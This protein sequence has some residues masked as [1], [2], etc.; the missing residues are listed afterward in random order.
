VSLLDRGRRAVSEV[1]EVAAIRPDGRWS[2]LQIALLALL[3]LFEIADVV[4]FALAIGSLGLEA[5]Q[6]PLARAVYGLVGLA[7]LAAVKG[8]AIC[9]ILAF[10]I[11]F[12]PR[13]RLSTVLLAG[14]VALSSVGAIG[15]LEA[16]SGD[17]HLQ[18]AIGP[19]WSGPG[20]DYGTPCGNYIEG[21]GWPRC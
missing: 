5:E 7:G 6:N 16:Y 3:V 1:R 10:V 2:R 19:L 12:F 13:D 9:L 15:N 21:P 11:R 14:C 8:L 18:G 17:A 20:P 4:T